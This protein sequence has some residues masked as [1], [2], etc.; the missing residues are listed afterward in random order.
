MEAFTWKQ[1]KRSQLAR[2]LHHDLNAPKIS[3][4]KVFL[5]QNIENVHVVL[6]GVGLAEEIFGKLVATLKGNTT[7]SHPS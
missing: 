5:Q 6:E 4:L 7:R 1:V 2:N 3:Y